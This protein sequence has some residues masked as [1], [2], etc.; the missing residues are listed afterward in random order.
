MKPG[1]LDPQGS[2]KVFTCDKH[3]HLLP[4]EQAINDPLGRSGERELLYR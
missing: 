4:L 2:A 3:E 1:E